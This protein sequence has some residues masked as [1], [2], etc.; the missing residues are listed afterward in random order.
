MYQHHN[1]ILSI[2][3]RLLYEDWGLMSYYDYKYKCKTGK[4]VR[5]K[6]GR[7]AGN[8][9]FISYYDL[10]PDLKAICIKKLG[11]PQKVVVVN[12]L[13]K[14]L[15]PDIEA[16]RFFSSHRKPN[17]KA[18]AQEAQIEKA[19]SVMILNA[20]KTV[21]TSKGAMGKA[22]GKKRTKLWEEISTAVNALD[23]NRWNFNLPGNPRSLRRKY[24]KY[25]KKNYWA[26]IHANEGT[27]HAKKVTADIE[28]LLVSLYCLPNKPYIAAVADLY[29]EFLEG[30]LEVIDIKT[31]EVFNRF[32]FYKNDELITVSKKNVWN[33]IKKPRNQLIIKKYRDGAYDFSHKQRPHVNRTA[34]NYSMSKISLD[35]SDIM[36]TKLPDGSK[37]M[38]YYAFD[39]MSTALIG[40]AHSKEKTHQLFLDCIANM[41]RF[42]S[43]K[44]LGVPMQMEVEHHL[45]K[46]FKDGLMQAGNMFPFVRWC[47]PT[48]SQEKY[49]ERLI[50]TKKYGVQKDNNQNVG[51]HYSRRDSNRITQQKIFDAEND[52]Y[53]FAKA[54]YKEIVAQDLQEQIEYNNELHPN[55]KLFK[56]MSR[57]E[58]FLAHVNPE[59]PQLDKA[60]LAKYIGFSTRTSIRR[61]QYVVVQ[62]GKY[63][64]ENPQVIDRL[65]PNNLKVDAYYLPNEN[66]EV[67]EVFIYQ[68][69]LYVCQCKPAPTFNRANAEWTDEDAQGYQNAT[70][71]ISQF[72]KMVK[73]DTAMQL[74]KVTIL[75]KPKTTFEA[76]PI[77]I[78]DIEQEEAFEFETVNAQQRRQKAINDL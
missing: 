8:E 76:N 56:G 5:T 46:D 47:N 20:I 3:A 16:A 21:L 51:R 68:N 53:K 65:A 2:P 71:Y 12:M 39:V 26:F 70:K 60:Q 44:G 77:T 42:T 50:G 34:P 23:S 15:V 72:D 73:E 41:F 78:P 57:L 75:K 25:I 52:N 40:I 55:Q 24:D 67:T 4:L 45:V 63:Q 10:P 29:L 35:D 14:Y 36:H 19:T 22:F 54:S 69:G 30:D 64:L 37:V 59:L 7:G 43:S 38:A 28:S 32:E 58:V 17:G 74:N 31:G 1:Q 61:N 62:Y 13:E 18:L 9:A 11:D 33:Y 49:A 66:N 48:N 27:Q 6:E